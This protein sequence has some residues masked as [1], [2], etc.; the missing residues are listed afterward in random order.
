MKCPICG[1]QRF[2]VKDPDDEYE[3]YPFDGK[4]GQIRFDSEVNE[5]EAPQVIET[6]ETYCDQCAWHGPLQEM[7]KQ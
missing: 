6:T 7:K 5:S 1:C 3:M 4:D 2:Y